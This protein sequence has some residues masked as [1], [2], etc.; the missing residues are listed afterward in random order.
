M[1]PYVLTTSDF[2][3]SSA[4]A[5]TLVFGAHIRTIDPSW[6]A[7]LTLSP[8]EK[9]VASLFF[10]GDLSGQALMILPRDTVGQAVDLILRRYD[11]R[12]PIT[13]QEVFAEMINIYT[14]SLAVDLQR[15]GLLLDIAPPDAAPRIPSHMDPGDDVLTCRMTT[16]TGL[17][18]VFCYI[19]NGWKGNHVS[20]L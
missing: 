16:D 19:I 9:V 8:D 18:F 15:H 1:E 6:G 14:A 2:I 12:T 17:S 5:L 20:D 3:T 11:I 10:G 13:E 7:D 4:D